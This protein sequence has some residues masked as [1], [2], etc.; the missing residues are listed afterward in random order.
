MKPVKRVIS[1]NCIKRKLNGTAKADWNMIYIIGVIKHLWHEL[2][3]TLE[4][5]L[6]QRGI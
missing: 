1:H 4:K 5:T 3:I 2:R 6:T